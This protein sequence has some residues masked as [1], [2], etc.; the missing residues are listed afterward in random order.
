MISLRPPY[1]RPALGDVGG[2]WSDRPGDDGG[3][4]LNVDDDLRRI[5]SAVTRR[6][7]D[8]ETDREPGG[9]IRAAMNVDGQS[10]PG[11]AGGV[12]KPVKRLLGF[13]PKRREGIVS[14]RHLVGYKP[15]VRAGR[16]RRTTFNRSVQAVGAVMALLSDALELA[17]STRPAVGRGLPHDERPV[18]HARE[19]GEVELER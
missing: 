1:I 4:R 10:R 18:A 2:V 14:D 19:G 16:T 11:D 15:E 12:G 5:L 17:L 3:E 7:W 13:E 6:G 8:G 9:L